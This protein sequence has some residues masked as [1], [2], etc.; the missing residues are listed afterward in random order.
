MAAA[1]PA[2]V[3]AASVEVDGARLH[4]YEAG[5]GAPVVLLHDLTPGVNG[6]LYWRPILEQLAG[7]RRVIALDLPGFGDSDTVVLERSRA[8]HTAD[9][10]VGLLDALDLKTASVV[11]GGPGANTAAWFAALHPRRCERLVM[12]GSAGGHQYFAPGPNDLPRLNVEATAAPTEENLRNLL[13]VVVYNNFAV[14]HELVGEFLA[15]VEEHPE[16]IES[17]A[18]SP[19]DMHIP[20]VL[21]SRI[22]DISAPTLVLSGLED[23]GV[24]LDAQ[25][26]FARLIYDSRLVVFSEAG[27]WVQMDKPEATAELLG[28]FLDGERGVGR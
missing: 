17:V 25:I 22:Y 19:M 28:E 10:I 3:S 5:A 15:S 21:E 2:G 14:S 11:G 9:A 16:H 8:E 20:Q 27:N 13:E 1:L 12:I 4:Y 18:A 26:G 24:G 23:R 6:W 7:G